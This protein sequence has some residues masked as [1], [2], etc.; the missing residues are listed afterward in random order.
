MSVITKL[1]SLDLR[2]YTQ[3]AGIALANLGNTVS[4]DFYYGKKCAYANLRKLTLARGY[5]KILESYIPEDV[6]VLATRKIIYLTGTTGSID[7]NILN[8]TTQTVTVPFNTSLYQTALDLQTALNALDYAATISLVTALGDS[9]VT[10]TPAEIT[11]QAAT[12]TGINGNG[13]Q[14]ELVANGGNSTFNIT[15]YSYLQGGRNALTSGDNCVTEEQMQSVIL[16]NLASFLNI[17]FPQP[18]VVVTELEESL[19]LLLQETGDLILQE[20]GDFLLLE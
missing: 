3:Y 18:G 16:P 10:T 14:V 20:N 15:D 17:V 12:G 9:S 11:I 19:S 5:M 8:S 2:Y 13:I 4:N 6:E 1:T 7:I